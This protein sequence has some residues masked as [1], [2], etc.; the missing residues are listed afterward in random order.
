MNLAAAVPKTEDL[1]GVIGVLDLPGLEGVGNGAESEDAKLSA[2]AC[3]AAQKNHPR[4]EPR[5]RVLRE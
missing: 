4:R 5:Q 2:R 3:V 1:A